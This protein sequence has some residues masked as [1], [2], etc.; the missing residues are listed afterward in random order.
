MDVRPHPDP[1]PQE[2]ENRLRVAG[3][4]DAMGKRGSSRS[5]DYNPEMATKTIGVSTDAD[6]LSL[7]PGERAGVRASVTID[8]EFHRFE[9]KQPHM[10]TL[11]TITLYARGELAARVG[12]DAAFA[13]IAAL[14]LMM[15]DYDPDSELMQLSRKPVGEPVHVS[16]ELFDILQKSQRIAELSDGAFDVTIGPVV[17]QWR[18][19][20]RTGDLP[21]AETL[22]RVR[23]S[24]GWQKLKLDPRKQTVTLTVPDMQLDLGGIA[25]GYAADQALAVLRSRG[26]PRA[27][28]AASGDLAIGDPPPG[29]RNWRVAVG[30]LDSHDEKLS[31]ILFLNNAAVSTSGDTEQFV[32]IGG[33]RY[34]HIV[35]PHTGLGLTERLQVTVIGRHAT[36]TDALATAA[37]VLGVRRGIALLESGPNLEGIFIRKT[38]SETKVFRSKRSK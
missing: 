28:V 16:D 29:K 19:A 33:R 11:F 31:R 21:A 37:S 7:C 25:K 3:E 17:R 38:A 12:A 30:K 6:M 9:F 36:D 23:E 26:L 13:K 34:S 5:N 20:R 27:L 4:M 24:V 35:N 32:E 15:T 18:R 14:D 1:L 2:R 22:S 8:P 10:G